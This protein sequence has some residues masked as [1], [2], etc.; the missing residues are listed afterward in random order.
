MAEFVEILDGIMGSSKSKNT[1]E[2]IDNN[3]NER[4]IFVSPLLSEVQSDGRLCNAVSNVTFECPSTTDHD[5][6][7]SHLLNLL[8]NGVNIACTHSLY[9]AITDKHLELIDRMGY[10][11]VIDE[12]VEVINGVK[13]YSKDDFKW[14]MD[15]GDISVDEKDGMINWVSDSFVGNEHKYY[16]FKKLCEYHAL[17]ATKRDSSM[18]VTQLPV[19]LFTVAKRVIIL[20]YMFEGNVL[21]CFLKLKGIKTKTFEDVN[22]NFRDG[23]EIAKLITLI[24]PNEVLNT[25]SLSSSWYDEATSK[26]LNNVAKYISNVCRVSKANFDDV[27]Y[28]LPKNRHVGS[29]TKNLVKPPKFYRKREGGV[30]KYCW[31]AVQTRATN[32]YKHKWCVVHCFNRFPLVSVSSYL[33]DY[34]FPVDFKTFAKSE[35]CQWVWR[36]RIR[37]MQPIVLAIGNKRMYKMFNEWLEEISTIST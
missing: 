31:L 14:L 23:K 22:I 34:G 12:E 29:T 1:I 7:S 33:S 8:Q 36:S 35:L 26:E 15:E 4:Y 17:Y 27:M 37:D 24:P 20:T 32:D 10:I 2:W 9:L 5:T 28:T 19:K 11:L 21:D 6:K 13:D 18:M 25:Y 30:W 3:P 16:L